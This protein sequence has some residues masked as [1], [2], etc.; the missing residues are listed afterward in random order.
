[1]AGLHPGGFGIMGW[2]SDVSRD[3][4][5]GMNMSFNM[6]NVSYG[7]SDM[8]HKWGHMIWLGTTVRWV[9]VV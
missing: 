9:P 4:P 3:V 2:V 5:K 1:M 7:C 8:S 6:F